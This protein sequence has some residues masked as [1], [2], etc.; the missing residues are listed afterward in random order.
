MCIAIALR[1]AMRSYYGQRCGCAV[2]LGNGY[3]HA[4]C[5]PAGAYHASSGKSGAM[6]NHGGWHD[7]GDYGRYVVNSGISTGT[8][9][10]AWEMFPQAHARLS[11]GHS[12]VGRQAA[13]CIWPRFAG[14]WTGCCPMQDED[15]GVWHKQTSEH[16]C[17]FIMP[18]DDKLTSYVIGTG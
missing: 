14:T 11:A 18:E 8:L 6:Q 12:R 3:K 5:H 15:G 7:A 13:G 4:A 16:F 2:D 9:L 17:G 1:L 10:W